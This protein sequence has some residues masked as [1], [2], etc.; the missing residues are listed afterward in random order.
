MGSEVKESDT[1]KGSAQGG[2]T[3]V[4]QEVGGASADI[5]HTVMFVSSYSTRAKKSFH[6]F[7]STT[8]MKVSIVHYNY[9]KDGNPILCTHT[10]NKS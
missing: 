8:T 10:N 1:E 5:E 2:G 9:K 7:S 4:P 6:F 3:G